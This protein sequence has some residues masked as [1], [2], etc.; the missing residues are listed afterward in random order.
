LTTAAPQLA[1]PLATASV[2]TTAN[3]RCD[4]MTLKH[5]NAG[6]LWT[7]LVVHSGF[8]WL[9][10]TD[11]KFDLQCGFT[12]FFLQIPAFSNSFRFRS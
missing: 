1:S 9:K 8:K 10:P 4:A 11:N 6:T 2:A 12:I 3:R 5:K 7:L